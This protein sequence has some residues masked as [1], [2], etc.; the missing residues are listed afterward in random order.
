[1]PLA[2][3]KANWLGKFTVNVTLVTTLGPWLM[4]TGV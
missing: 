1:M 4:T 3:L 2:T